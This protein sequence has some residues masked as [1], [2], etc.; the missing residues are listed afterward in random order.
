M[1]SS[2]GASTGQSDLDIESLEIGEEKY[3]PIE[4]RTALVRSTGAISVRLI[5]TADGIEAVLCGRRNGEENWN[6]K[7]VLGES[8]QPKQVHAVLQQVRK[9]VNWMGDC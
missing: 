9:E 1:I 7:K 4:D 3:I 6:A 8:L 5:K 2:V